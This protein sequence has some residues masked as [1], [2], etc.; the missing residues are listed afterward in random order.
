MNDLQRVWIHFFLFIHISE[1]QW[2]WRAKNLISFLAIDCCVGLCAGNCW[3]SVYQ[4][5]N[6]DGD[7]ITTEPIILKI[8]ED[9]RIILEEDGRVFDN[10]LEFLISEVLIEEVSGL[11]NEGEIILRDKMNQVMKYLTLEGKFEKL[12]GYHIAILNSMRNKEKVNIPLFL[13]KSME[14]SVRA[15]KISKRKSPLHQGL[16]K[17]LVDFEMNKKGNVTGPFKG[18]FTRLSGT[19]VSKAQLLLGSAPPSPLLIPGDTASDYDGDYGSREG[20]RPT[21]NPKE[22]GGRKRKPPTQVLNANL[23]K[24]SRRSTRDLGE[25]SNSLKVLVSTP[26]EKGGSLSITCACINLLALEITNY[27]K[28]VVKNMKDLNAAKDQQNPPSK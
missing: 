13:L 10:G 27:M 23:P 5:F 24:C 3:E 12:F 2:W 20:D 22:G 9:V 1:Q 16:M 6:M 4:S 28:E 25:R 26:T 8:D 21:A 17:M 7:P 11:P 19:P 15:V 18:G 14:K